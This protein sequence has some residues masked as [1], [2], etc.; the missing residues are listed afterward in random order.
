MKE[1]TIG[2]PKSKERVMK[3]LKAIVK[4]QNKTRDNASTM[5]DSLQN[6]AK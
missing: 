5:T 4:P 3:T 6:T 2:N 1:K